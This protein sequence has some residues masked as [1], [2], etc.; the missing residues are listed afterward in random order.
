MSDE[1]E[2]FDE[3]TEE[4]PGKEDLKDRLVAIF[5]TG[6]H[7]KR[8][9]S[10]PGSKPYDWYE[11]ITLVLDDGPNW[12]GLKVVDGEQVPM[13]VGSVVE[14]E[15][16]V[17]LDNFQ[18]TQTGLVSRLS[19]RVAGDKPKTF[20][21]MVGRV[22]SRPNKTKGHSASWSISKPTEDDKVIARQYNDLFRAV[23]AE[24]EASLQPKDEDAFE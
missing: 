5:V 1:L 21:P 6:E 4:F 11:T 7:G 14:N 13:L 8:V 16:P 22:N 17:R 15:G 19:S 23:A 12:T 18:F 3:A 20:M 24:L 10:A 9:G 2:F